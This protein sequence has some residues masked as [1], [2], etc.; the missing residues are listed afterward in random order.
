M[1]RLI[2]NKETNTFGYQDKFLWFWVDKTAKNG[3]GDDL[4]CCL[5]GFDTFE[6]ALIEAQSDFLIHP[7]CL[8]FIRKK[9]IEG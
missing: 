3:Y 4:P 9:K 1:T 2:Y 5:V 8:P 6:E 7:N